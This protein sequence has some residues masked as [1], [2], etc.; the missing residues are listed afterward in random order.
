MRVNRIA[1]LVFAAQSLL[2]FPALQAQSA[3]VPPI[4][5]APTPV[6]VTDP[7][8]TPIQ[9]DDHPL[10]GA[11]E[12]GIGSWGPRHSYLTP[13]IRIAETLESNPLLTGAD[14]GSYRGFTSFASDTQL[15]RY[16][17]SSAELRY[18][19]AL[20]YDT[21]AAIQGLD[22][23]TNTHNLSFSKRFTLSNWNLLFDDHAQYSQA[24][25][26]G[27]VGMEGLGNVVGQLAQWQG[28]STSQLTSGTLKPGIA[29]DQTILN[30]QTG[31]V[32]NS[33]LGQA[34]F[35]ADSRDVYT[36]A[37]TYSLLHFTSGPYNDSR[38][39]AIFGGY[40]H[41]L[42][43]RDSFGVA[44]NYTHI[45]FVH[46]PNTVSVET[47]TGIYSRRIS[48]KLSVEG[49]L[50]PQFDSDD[51]GGV[52]HS[53]VS[54]Q[55]HASA[56]YRVKRLMLDTRVDRSTTAGSGVLPGA[57]T[58]Q[59]QNSSSFVVS[60]NW[61]STVNFGV[62]RNKQLNG[63]REYN[64]QFAGITFTRRLGVYTSIFADYNLQRQTQDSNC[65]GTACGFTGHNNVFGIGL[66]WSY[67]PVGIE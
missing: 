66:S 2:L 49:G 57:T 29:P 44:A 37:G 13:S 47:V 31:R 50:G 4:H 65:T 55:G 28:T 18:A 1:V 22:K 52:T 45:T 11:M 46:L 17:G 67:K 38:Q 41:A 10:T 40:N 16:F 25:N 61:S 3:P 34:E 60:R 62:A 26:F 9:P 42:S 27:A 39:A 12:L 53:E 63:Q 6:L 14:S 7:I 30:G 23:F 48:G 33:V 54:W 35:H 24:S 21:R 43:D 8:Q 5:D 36:A 58:T 64:T 19:G 56:T 20:R 32:S 15:V 59:L 51:E